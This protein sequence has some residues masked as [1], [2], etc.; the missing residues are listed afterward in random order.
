MELETLYN[1]VKENYRGYTT[2]DLV[3][4]LQWEKFFLA[5]L[6]E[7]G[8]LTEE[9]YH[10]E[11]SL[12]EQAIKDIEGEIKRRRYIEKRFGNTD[13]EIIHTIKD[14]I[15]IED[16]VAWYCEVTVYRKNWS[17]KCNRHGRDKH[18]SGKIY[19]DQQ[20]A[21]CFGCNA[22]GDIFDIVQLY[23][24]IDLPSAIHKLATHIGIDTK[25]L[26]PDGKYVSYEMGG[27]EE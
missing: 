8:E 14:R 9:T 6:K 18:P 1:A 19:I 26:V 10:H 17:Y 24:N 12:T 11:I 21:W 3:C 23:E 20:T 2:P 13:R 22:G 4:A 15:K 27:E 7:C 25:P 16:V 5:N